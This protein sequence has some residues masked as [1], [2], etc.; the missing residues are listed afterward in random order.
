MTGVLDWDVT[1]ASNTTVGGV[2]VVENNAPS[3]VNDGMRAMMAEGKAGIVG[4]GFRNLSLAA[5]VGSS[6]LTIALKGWDGNDPSGTNA[7]LIP[8]RSATAATGTPDPLSVEAAASLVISSGSTLGTSSGV[9]HRIWVVGVN[10][11]GTFRLGAVFSPTSI[12][13]DELV[14]TTAEGG[15]GGADTA[16][17]IYTGSGATSKAMRILGYVESTQATAGTWAT[18]PSKVHVFSGLQPNLADMQI[19]RPE[20]KDYAITHNSVSSSGGTLT[21]DY[22]TGQSFVC[23]LT[24]NVTTVTVS[25]PP[26]SGKYGEIIVK[27]IQDASSAYTVTWASA[28]TF[29]GGVDHT[30]STT[31]SAVDIVTLRTID[32]GTTWYCDFSNGYA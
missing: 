28:Y 1:A 10:D 16:G 25:N 31:L 26:A 30:M 5:S 2:T 12:G 4:Q 19:T 24:E 32:G 18:S 9:L 3:T 21:L 7:V 27:L 22:S 13:D 11:G 15:S 17:T 29:P 20:I 6:A 23:T 14:T 8:F